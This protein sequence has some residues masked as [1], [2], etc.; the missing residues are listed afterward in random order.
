MGSVHTRGGSSDESKIKIDLDDPILT[1][2]NDTPATSPKLIGQQRRQSRYKPDR[3]T[4]AKS[5]TSSRTAVAG[6]DVDRGKPPT[7]H[8]VKSSKRTG[9]INRGIR[10]TSYD[11]EF[12]VPDDE[13][14]EHLDGKYSESGASTTCDI[15]MTDDGT[16]L[17]IDMEPEYAYNSDILSSPSGS[18]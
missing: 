10:A 2:D 13:V 11:L 5:K 4:A 1:W 17:F 8:I 18:L 14:T 3:T 16:D 7:S 12:I 6:D 15:D 9:G